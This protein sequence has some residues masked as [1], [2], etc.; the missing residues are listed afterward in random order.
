MYGGE[1]E[2]GS[3]PPV[4]ATSFPSSGDHDRGSEPGAKKCG[5]HPSA[6]ITY[7]SSGFPWVL[8]QTAKAIFEPSGDQTGPLQLGLQCVSCRMP[9]P[10]A[11]ITNTCDVPFGANLT[12]NAIL[13]PSREMLGTPLRAAMAVASEVG[14]GS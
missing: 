7:T 8:G 1:R 5:S 3:I 9:V 12:A 11:F 13:V 10:S 2:G 14:R 6:S 4:Q